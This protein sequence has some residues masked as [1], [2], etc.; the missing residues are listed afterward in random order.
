M[1]GDWEGEDTDEED[2]E[3]P[4]TFPC[5]HCGA[6]LPQGWQA[7]S[8]QRLPAGHRTPWQFASTQEAPGHA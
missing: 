6:S 4:K 1:N 2:L 8:P 7:P 5:P 3:T